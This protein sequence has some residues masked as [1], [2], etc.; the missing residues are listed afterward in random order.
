MIRLVNLVRN[1]TAF[2]WRSA[3]R[4]LSEQRH[5]GGRTPFLLN[6]FGADRGIVWVDLAVSGWS[7]EVFVAGNRER[8]V[9]RQS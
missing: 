5:F 6:L 7:V 9:G 4:G 8:L 3:P 2:S 1:A